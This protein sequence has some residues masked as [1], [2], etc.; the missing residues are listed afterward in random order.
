MNDIEYTYKEEQREKSRLAR[1]SHSTPSRLRRFNGLRTPS[2]FLTAEEKAQLNGRVVTYSMED[3][4]ITFAEFKRLP[5]EEQARKLEHYLVSRK[6]KELAKLWNVNYTTLIKWK[7]RL[8][9]VPSKVEPVQ[10]IERIRVQE[11]EHTTTRAFTLKLAKSLSG[12]E[13][14]ETLLNMAGILQDEK[15]YDF[16][17]SIESD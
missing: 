7:N 11:S 8:L 2:E 4:I 16:V 13:I 14:K 5:E 9:G 17:L 6:P 12:A 3:M 1:A 15:T 10:K